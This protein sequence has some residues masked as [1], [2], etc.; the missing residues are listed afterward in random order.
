MPVDVYL[1]GHV[2]QYYALERR[3]WS[4]RMLPELQFLLFVSD[5]ERTGHF[6]TLYWVVSSIPRNTFVN[7]YSVDF[8]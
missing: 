1:F 3:V 2:E 4:V 7:Q 8:F 6:P 5:P